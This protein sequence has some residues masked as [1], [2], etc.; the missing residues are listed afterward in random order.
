MPAPKSTKGVATGTVR[1]RY[2]LAAKI[3]IS[4]TTGRKVRTKRWVLTAAA[5]AAAKRRAAAK[6]KKSRR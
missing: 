3:T 1:G 4:Q 2:R 5:K 6:K